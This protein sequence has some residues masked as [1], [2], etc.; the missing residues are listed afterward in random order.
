MFLESREILENKRKMLD[1][2]SEHLQNIWDILNKTKEK[3]VGRWPTLLVESW[4]PD[5][6]SQEQLRYEGWAARE[7]VAGVRVWFHRPKRPPA[8]DTSENVHAE[9]SAVDP[10]LAEPNYW[11]MFHERSAVVDGLG[12]GPHRKIERPFTG[13]ISVFT[14][15]NMFA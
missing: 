15:K 2:I 11:N 9:N 1:T 5:L 12:S 4:V 6:H 7:R 13:K 8:K 3:R 10:L 14:N